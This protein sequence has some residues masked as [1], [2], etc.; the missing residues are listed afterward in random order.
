VSLKCNITSFGHG[1]TLIIHLEKHVQGLLQY[2]LMLRLMMNIRI[3]CHSF[4]T[5]SFVV[6]ALNISD[7]V[8]LVITSECVQEIVNVLSEVLTF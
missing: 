2:H 7:S 6:D 5:S 4:S 8:V 3:Q 1:V